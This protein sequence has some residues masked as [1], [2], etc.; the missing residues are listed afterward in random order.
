[1]AGPE[2]APLL[3]HLETITPFTRIGR[4]RATENG[5]VRITGLCQHARIA[6]PLDIRP[7]GG[8]R[9]RG[10]VVRLDGDDTLALVEGAMRGLARGDEVRL[11]HDPGL[12]PDHS[13]IGRI[14]DADGMPL[15]GRPMARGAVP[16]PLLRSP[17]PAAA[18]RPFG[19]RLE[20]GLCVFN[21]FLPLARGQRIGLFA[22]S[23]VGK[24]TLLGQLA[25]GVSAD[26][27]VIA[28]IG[29]RGRELADFVTNVLGS[30]GLG[31]SIIVT[32]TSDRSPV[33]KWRAAW[34]AMAV[35]E[36]FRDVGAHV[37]LLVDSLTRF[38][39]AHREVALAAGEPASMRGFPP[40]TAQM[41][42]EL[43]ERAGPGVGGGGD[44]TAV[45]SVLV[46]GSD[47]EEPVAD[48]TRGVLDGHVVLDR[49]I[50][51]R[52]RFPAVDVLRSVS[53]SLPAAA[54]PGENAT[55]TVARRLLGAHDEAELMIRSG[56]YVPG[57][58]DLLD[59]AVTAWPSLDAFAGTVEPADSRASFAALAA[60]LPDQVLDQ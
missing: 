16:V 60:C 1:M 31:R 15:D 5:V 2:F 46:A 36:R 44:I 9:I 58:D 21:T 56:L 52:G 41:I 8:S 34:A 11:L 20:T 29:E 37:L 25:R 7:H 32:A 23:G 19:A 18:R 40:S 57:S 48:I 47:M 3:N 26:M 12:A 38:A 28:L 49:R 50:A 35:A 42:M 51:E 39:E 53:R 55:L 43:C 33:E 27:A 13:W 14:I 10:E 54:S 30:D 24:S 22:G 59:A 45:F 17:P 4:I 6:D